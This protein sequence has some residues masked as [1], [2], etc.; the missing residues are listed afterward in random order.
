MINK[1]LKEKII[2]V[3]GAHYTGPIL[4]HL[5]EKEVLNSEGKPY[6]RQSIRNIVGAVNDRENLVVE[7]HIIDLLALKQRKIKLQKEKTSKVLKTR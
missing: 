3:L 6:S 1:K 7:G 5:A 2:R 4:Q